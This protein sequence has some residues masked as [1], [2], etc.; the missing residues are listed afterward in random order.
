MDG[1]LENNLKLYEGAKRAQFE[2][3]IAKGNKI[4]NLWLPANKK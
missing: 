2:K 1:V 3:E 4:A